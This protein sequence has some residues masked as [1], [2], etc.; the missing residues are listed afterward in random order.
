MT[1]ED[2][3]KDILEMIEELL[4]K[5]KKVQYKSMMAREINFHRRELLKEL[6]QK[7][8]GEK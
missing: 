7:I 4:V 5:Y 3:K 6:T 8:K 2:L 1:E